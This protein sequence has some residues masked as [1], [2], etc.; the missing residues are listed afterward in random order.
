MSEGAAPLAEDPGTAANR[1]LLEAIKDMGA[2]D[3][4]EIQRTRLLEL[5]RINADGYREALAYYRKELV[6][7]IAGGADPIATW[8][9]YGCRIAGLTVAGTTL[10]VGRDGLSAR[11]R[12]PAAAEE[13]VLHLP[14]GEGRALLVALPPDLSPA[15]DATVAFL[16]KE[17]QSLE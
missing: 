3:P 6:P 16:V 11:Y 12:S 5:R 9:E 13:L 7:A 17:R 15:Q 4:R 8:T 10:S 2:P 1:I 14:H